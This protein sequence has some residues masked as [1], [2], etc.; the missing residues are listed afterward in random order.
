MYDTCLCVCL[1]LVNCLSF[2]APFHGGVCIRAA[3]V[4]SSLPKY[5]SFGGS[6]KAAQ[7]RHHRKSWGLYLFIELVFFLSP[8]Y[9]SL[10]WQTIRAMVSFTRFLS[11]TFYIVLQNPFYVCAFVASHY[12]IFLPNILTSQI[13]HMHHCCCNWLPSLSPFLLQR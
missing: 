2:A 8:I 9:G 1:T 5:A 11:F 6:K 12:S 7:K 4:C 13:G 3:C 10:L